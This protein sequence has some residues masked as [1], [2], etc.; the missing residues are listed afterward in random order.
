M[1]DKDFEN[2]C[3]EEQ[4]VSFI[5]NQIL[6]YIEGLG[7]TKIPKSHR[8]HLCD[9]IVDDIDGLIGKYLSAQAASNS[10]FKKF[11]REALKS[12]SD[13][14]FSLIINQNFVDGRLLDAYDDINNIL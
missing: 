11:I 14:L 9:L 6:R 1:I 4:S 8:E 7:G 2:S 12:I 13:K 3:E 5:T 10:S